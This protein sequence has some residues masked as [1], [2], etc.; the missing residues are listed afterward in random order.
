[1]IKLKKRTWI[2]LFSLV[3]LLVAGYYFTRPVLVY[4]P[5]GEECGAC[6][7]GFKAVEVSRIPFLNSAQSK[8]GDCTET[9][10]FLINGNHLPCESSAAE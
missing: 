4:S 3:V 8:F 1:M 10:L 2:T 9:P 5:S 6:S 7:W